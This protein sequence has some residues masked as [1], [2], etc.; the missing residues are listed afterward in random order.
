MPSCDIVREPVLSAR[1]ESKEPPPAARALEAPGAALADSRP[2]P[3]APEVAGGPAERERRSP[4][5]GREEPSV[6][7]GNTPELLP[8]LPLAPKSA[9]RSIGAS[10]DLKEGLAMPDG[11]SC[12]G[13]GGSPDAR[14]G[15][16]PDPEECEGVDCGAAA[17]RRSSGASEGRAELTTALYAPIG[18]SR[19]EGVSK[20]GCRPCSR[21]TKEDTGADNLTDPAAAPTAALCIT[22][23]DIAP[24]F[25]ECI[26]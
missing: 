25:E 6:K 1:A 5:E 20:Y 4:E 14:D 17:A 23:A 10:P 15:A 2:S 12:G 19:E 18:R 8:S 24:K 7:S 9:P 21:G 26:P 11:C 13:R 22:A 3:R 16:D